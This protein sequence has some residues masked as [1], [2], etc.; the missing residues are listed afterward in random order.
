MVIRANYHCKETK[1]EVTEVSADMQLLIA[2]YCYKR[3]S[4]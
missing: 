2:L 3:W 4:L 1:F